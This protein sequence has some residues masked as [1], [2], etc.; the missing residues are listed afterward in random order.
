M[1]IVS[2]KNPLP[3]AVP[4]WKGDEEYFSNSERYLAKRLQAVAADHQNVARITFIV[5]SG[6]GLLAWLL[7]GVLA[8]HWLVTGGLP[9]WARIVWFLAAIGGF[10]WAVSRWFLPLLRHRINLVYAA[11]AIEQGHP[12]LHNDLINTVLLQEHS[13]G[14]PETITRSL[15]KRTALGVAQQPADV[16]AD[17]SQLLKLVSV[18]AALVAFACLYQ[19][20]SPKNL[21]VS[22]LRL[23]AP[24]SRILPPTRVRITAT[25]FAWRVAPLEGQAG[26]G[27][28]H[29][30]DVQS[31]QVSLQRGRQLIIS[32]TIRGRRRGEQPQVRVS[33]LNGD[34]SVDVAASWLVPMV[35][36]GGGTAAEDGEA[37]DAVADSETVAR[38]EDFEAVLP[39][40]DRGMDR[41]AECSI[42]VGD[43]RTEP[44]RVVLVDV[45][46]MATSRATIGI[47]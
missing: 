3:L 29:P 45:P 38:R 46:S 44:V 35:R 15:K 8:D 26:D 12:D 33:P 13:E 27:R 25:E 7:V 34:G 16:L 32:T 47:S 10:A 9:A 5:A 17:R 42:I 30:L 14:I 39:G 6:I 40:S 28:L 20:L 18:M 43:G 36:R 23:A 19:L 4:V 2:E 37:E 41:P 24:W 11:R 22:G 31:G 21:V 1:A